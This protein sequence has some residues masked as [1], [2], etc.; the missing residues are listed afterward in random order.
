MDER[1]NDRMLQR[2]LIFVT[3]SIGILWFH[4]Y[5]N[6]R[7]QPDEPAG[8]AADQQPGDGAPEGEKPPEGDAEKLASAKPDESVEKPG[9]Q[10]VEEPAPD[11]TVEFPTQYV[12]LGSVDPASPYR[13]LV[14]LTNRGAALV[15]TELNVPA[16]WGMSS[17]IRALPR[18]N[19]WSR[20]SGREHRQRRPA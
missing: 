8:A 6:P 19:A 2:T 12:S 4:N 3:L 15:R 11:E 18:K 17:S 7:P 20:W 14:T 5:M 10:G 1:P 9:E 13:M 16:T